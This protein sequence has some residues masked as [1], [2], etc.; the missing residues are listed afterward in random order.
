MALTLVTSD[1]I[2]G[3][4]YS[5]LTGTVPTWNQNTTGNA[6][7]ATKFAS[8]AN[9][10]G[11]AFDGSNNIN[12]PGVNA[13]G[14]QNTS[15]T[16]AGL[17]A[18]LVVGSGGTGVTS[19]TALKN[20]L[21]DETWTFANNVTVGSNHIQGSDTLRLLAPSTILFL[22]ANTD[23]VFRTS[24]TSEKMRLLQ[25]GNFGIGT[26]SPAELLEI[27]KSSSPAI[28]LNQND[29]FKGIIRLGGNDLE[30][31]GSSGAMEFYNGSADGDGSALRMSI[32]SGGNTTFHSDARFEGDL[33]PIK[34]NGFIYFGS[35]STARIQHVSSSNSLAIN[36]NGGNV[37][38]GDSA[39]NYYANRLVLK[40]SDED[41]VTFL[42]DAGHKFWLCFADGTANH[43]QELAGHIAFDHAD[44]S[45]K[46]GGAAGHDWITLGGGGDITFANTSGIRLVSF[47]DNQ[48][49]LTNQS[50][51]NAGSGSDNR[52]VFE[53]RYRSSAND[54][55]ALG[56]IR[57]GKDSYAD[58]YYGGNMQFWTRINGGAITERMR[59]TSEGK[60]NFTG[61]VTNAHMMTII[62]SKST[63]FGIYQRFMSEQNNESSDFIRFQDGTEVK[64]HVFSNGNV[65]NKN[66]SYGAISDIKLKE[67]VV[68][69]PNKLDDILKVKVRNYN[70][71]ND[72]LKQIGV[73]AQEL[74]SIFPS[75]VSESPDTEIVDEKVVNLGTTTKSVKYS[76]FVPILIK[77]IQE[78]QVQI[79][80]LKKEVELLKNK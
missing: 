30:I 60:A 80:L 29:Q 39:F 61:S 10:G 14:N 36:T 6:A 37:G 25:G 51:Y 20:V 69:T 54:P 72:N 71:K 13:A 21:D 74:E 76:V 66:N 40:A 57:V 24:S 5:K 2:G 77:S 47:S 11:V 34:N 42:S 65:K 59:I 55:T 43:T 44:N 73:I 23:M 18:T 19:I 49:Y 38:I 46:L 50:A 22:D 33:Y 56:E 41:G 26:T 79:E 35:N 78:Q 67:N 32:A 62:N 52:L 48:L 8:A 28:R 12:L 68:N 4:D 64:F 27:K 63:P 17:S 16:A 15:G 1:L 45:M 58:G 31:R 70:F 7:T 53:G 3:L 9:I 75:L